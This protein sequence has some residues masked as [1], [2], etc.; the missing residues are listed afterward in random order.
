[1]VHR[2]SIIQT[3]GKVG[4]LLKPELAS[5]EYTKFDED[6]KRLA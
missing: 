2:R 6:I 5:S 1:M 3:L 4:Q